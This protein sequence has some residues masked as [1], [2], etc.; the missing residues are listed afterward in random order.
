MADLKLDLSRPVAIASRRPPVT[1]APAAV[2]SGA[3]QDGRLRYIEGN[4]EHPVNKW[5][6]LRQGLG[7]DHAALF[8]A[9]LKAAAETGRRRGSGEFVEIEWDERCRLPPTGCASGPRTQSDELAFFHRSRPEP[10]DRP[11]GGRRLSVR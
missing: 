4:P 2:A 10:G 9:R 8:A 11:A 3:H 6:A 5:R 7:R 1:C